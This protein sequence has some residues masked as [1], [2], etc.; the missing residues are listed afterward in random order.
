MLENSTRVYGIQTIPCDTQMRT[1]LDEVSPEELRPLYKDVFRQLQ[2]GK[3]IEKL[4][5]LEGCY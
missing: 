3:V 4:V 5:F 2:R 1:I